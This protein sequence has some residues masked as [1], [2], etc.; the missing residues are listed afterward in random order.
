RFNVPINVVADANPDT[1]DFT[2]TAA[3]EGSTGGNPFLLG[4]PYAVFGNVR[5]PDGARIRISNA[6]GITTA[7]TDNIR[8]VADLT[9]TGATATVVQNITGIGRATIG[10]LS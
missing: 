5:V 7:N 4:A 6:G 10:D 2:V 9:L 3:S 1:V 8:P